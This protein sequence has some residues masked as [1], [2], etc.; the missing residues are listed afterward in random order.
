MASIPH[1]RGKVNAIVDIQIAFKPS[2]PTKPT[3]MNLLKGKKVEAHLFFRRIPVDSL[4]ESEEALSQWL[5]NIYQE[6]VIYFY[7]F[8]WRRL[9]FVL[10]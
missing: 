4:P 2:E 9:I 8:L 5:H 3:V 1:L 7:Y 6:K 10:I